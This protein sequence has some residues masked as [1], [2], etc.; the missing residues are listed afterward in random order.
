MTWEE[1]HRRYEILETV[2]AE[3]H[4]DPDHFP[5]RPEYGALFAGPGGLVAAL[6]HRWNLRLQAQVDPE[7]D[8]ELQAEALERILRE[9]PAVDQLTDA[10]SPA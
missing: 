6:R 7:L 8:P 10:V 5:W 2:E 9:S 4:R 1:T 3:L